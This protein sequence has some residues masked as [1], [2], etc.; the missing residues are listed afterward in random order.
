LVGDGMV[1]GLIA[2]TRN[3]MEASGNVWI[4]REKANQLGELVLHMRLI[5]LQ[6][7]EVLSQAWASSDESPSTS[8]ATRLRPSSR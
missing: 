3:T 5:Q 2:L 8:N 6:G 4:S 1:T 7:F